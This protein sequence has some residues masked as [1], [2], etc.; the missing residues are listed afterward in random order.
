MTRRRKHVMKKL[1]RAKR[2]EE[3]LINLTDAQVGEY[4]GTWYAIHDSKEDQYG[5][6]GSLHPYDAAR[7]AIICDAYEI[8]LI[9]NKDKAYATL[10]L[11]DID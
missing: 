5:G 8:T 2:I 10:R 4:G 1:E 7:M 11:A 6:V 9:H 3:A